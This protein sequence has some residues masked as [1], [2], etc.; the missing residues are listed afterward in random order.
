MVFPRGSCFIL[1]TGST[2]FINERI[3]Q[4]FGFPLLFDMQPWAPAYCMLLKACSEDRAIQFF[5]AFL[6]CLALQES[7]AL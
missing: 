6:K 7:T 1:C 4:Y 3:I 5:M 2:L